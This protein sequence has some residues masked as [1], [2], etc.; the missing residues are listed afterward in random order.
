ML[1]VHQLK[2]R[3]YPHHSRAPE[4][5]RWAAGAD[6]RVFKHKNVWV[7]RSDSGLV[8][9]ETLDPSTVKINQLFV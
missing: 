7:F 4:S 6:V 2:R 9:F 1:S 3:V 8:H 5:V